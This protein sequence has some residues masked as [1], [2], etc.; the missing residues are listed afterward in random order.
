MW[1]NRHPNHLYVCM[2]LASLVKR[3]V[4]TVLLFVAIPSQLSFCFL[5][6][7]NQRCLRFC[8]CGATEALLAEFLDNVSFS[9][10]FFFCVCATVLGGGGG[11]TEALLH[12]MLFF[13][14]IHVTVLPSLPNLSLKIQVWSPECGF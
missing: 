8:C 6:N 9:L 7:H 11:D 5:G 12:C 3:G 13:F 4:H 10:V 2:W 1:L 14:I